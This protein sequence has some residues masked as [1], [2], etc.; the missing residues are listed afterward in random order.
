VNHG[1]AVWTDRNQ[2]GFW[3]KSVFLAD[4]ADRRDMVNMDELLSQ[5]SISFFKI[6]FTNRAQEAVVRTSRSSS[7]QMVSCHSLIWIPQTTAR[8]TTE[9]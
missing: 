8:G 9:L 5:F 7:I 4:V 1:V 2:I 6:K 3:I